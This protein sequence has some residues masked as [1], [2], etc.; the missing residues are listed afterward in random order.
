[1]DFWP[2]FAQRV[3]A[4]SGV[5][6]AL[7]AEVELGAVAAREATIEYGR[8]LREELAPLAREKDAVG[9]EHYSLASRFFLGA[10][11]DLEET[12][13]WGFAELARIEAD[14]RS[15]ADKIVPGG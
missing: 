15:V 5:S 1:D 6:G 3:N 8:F 4:D 2:K 9:R 12:Y 13:A 11:V 7:Q 14:M 10:A